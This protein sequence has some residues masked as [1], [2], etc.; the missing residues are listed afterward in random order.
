MKGKKGSGT[1]SDFHLSQG[2]ALRNE[3]M[4]TLHHKRESETSV[5]TSSKSVFFGV[6]VV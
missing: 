3:T 2:N 4:P 6:M 5:E 1:Q